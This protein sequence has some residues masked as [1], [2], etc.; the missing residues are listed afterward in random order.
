MPRIYFR[1]QY[2]GLEKT[3]VFAQV[4]AIYA[5]PYRLPCIV[6]TEQAS[7]CQFKVLNR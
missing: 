3:A 6:S 2:E 4:R 5:R 7:V 1:V